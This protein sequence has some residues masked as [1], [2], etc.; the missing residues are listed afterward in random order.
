MAVLNRLENLRCATCEH[1]LGNDAESRV[2]HI[3]VDK[4]SLTG[5]C[6]APRIDHAFSGFA[7]DRHVA[8]ELVMPEQWCRG[9]SLPAPFVAMRCDHGVAKKWFQHLVLQTA[10]G[11]VRLPF[12]QHSLYSFGTRDERH[13]RRPGRD[14]DVFLICLLWHSLEIVR[15]KFEDVERKPQGVFCRHNP[16]RIKGCNF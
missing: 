6:I 3:A 11:E 9:T 7:H 12:H 8:H 1:G 15:E 10:L 13:A 4:A 2:Q 14:D 16:G 5:G